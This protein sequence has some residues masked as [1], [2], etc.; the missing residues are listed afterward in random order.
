MKSP[1]ESLGGQGARTRPDTRFWNRYNHF[2]ALIKKNSFHALV[3]TYWHRSPQTPRKNDPSRG[4]LFNELVPSILEQQL[5]CLGCCKS[6]RWN[7]I[8]HSLLVSV[9]TLPN[10]FLGCR[11]LAL[12]GFSLSTNS[13]QQCVHKI[14]R[15]RFPKAPPI[16]T[17]SLIISID[18]R[19][20]STDFRER[21]EAAKNV[22]VSLLKPTANEK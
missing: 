1:G 12:A 18:F 9:E 5:L 6:H 14:G 3:L 20:P 10:L 4:G 22:S 17:F 8:R 15:T 11:V 13:D 7:E 19:T 2:T 16:V 21:L